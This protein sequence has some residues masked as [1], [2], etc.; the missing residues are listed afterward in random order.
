MAARKPP[1]ATITTEDFD[2]VLA[3]VI[4]SENLKA[5]TLLQVPGIYEIL[6]EYYNNAVLEAYDL[7][8][9][10]QHPDT[11]GDDES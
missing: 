9:A 1:H 8:Y 11:E 2:R 7:E 5:S 6:S 3:E 4:D 10:D